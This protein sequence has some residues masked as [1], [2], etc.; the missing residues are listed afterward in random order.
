MAKETRVGRTCSVKGTPK[1]GEENEIKK[2]E[3]SKQSKKKVKK[4][5]GKE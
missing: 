5:D 1:N 2:G 4:E 3:K